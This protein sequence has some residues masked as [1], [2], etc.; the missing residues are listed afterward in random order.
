M[1][2]EERADQRQQNDFGQSP[3]NGSGRDV[4][5]GRDA[6]DDRSRDQAGRPGRDD[7]WLSELEEDILSAHEPSTPESPVPP[8]QAYR[9]PRTTPFRT[10][11]AGPEPGQAPNGPERDAETDD[12]D[13]ESE[14]R[15]PQPPRA[16]GPQRPPTYNPPPR[17]PKGPSIIGP[18]VLILLG[19][20]F[21][22][23]SLG[24]I[25]WSVW[26]ALSRLWPV[27]LIVAGLDMLLGRRGPWGRAVAVLLALALVGGILFR[28]WPQ[29]DTPPPIARPAP[30]DEALVISRPLGSA[31]SAQIAVESSVS[32][33]RIKASELGDELVHGS[34]IPLSNERIDEQYEVVDGTAYY[35]LRSTVSIPVDARRGQGTW[36]LYLSPAVPISLQLDTGVAESDID[37]SGLRVTDLDVS[38]G[39]GDVRLT[40][41]AQGAVTGRIDAGVGQIFLRVPKG[42]PARIKVET[43]LGGT[44]VGGGFRREDGY[45]ITEDFRAG[46][47][48]ID[49]V[50]TGGIGHVVLQ[51]VD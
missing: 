51:I 17:S 20:F 30:V 26:D 43:G 4:P 16:H 41:P 8:V 45:F 49:L 44:D 18:F 21:L 13:R 48:A 33:L 31:T 11:A 7:A 46:Q 15:P 22:G 19:L 24:L 5:Q 38:T 47:E 27:L 14:R 42:R 35:R 10:A 23:Q 3:A 29:V 34:V 39:V 6:S 37:L 36:D 25:S 1:E 50:V 40:L 12:K 9:P 28:S 32:R 2:R